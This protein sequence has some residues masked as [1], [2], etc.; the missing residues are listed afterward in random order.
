MMFGPL[1][2]RRILAF[3]LGLCTVIL[4][5]WLPALPGYSQEA[6]QPVLS[7]PVVLDGTQLFRVTAAADLSAQE[8]ASII[9]QR[10]QRLLEASDTN[11]GQFDVTV[12]E[13]SNK[14]VVEVNNQDLIT[15]TEADAEIAG[16][17]SPAT[18]ARKIKLTIERAL[19]KSYL[20]RQE[21]FLIRSLPIAV[22]VLI[23]AGLGHWLVGLL[24]AN[25]VRPAL[26]NITAF[27]VQNGESELTGVNLLL[28]VSLFLVR[29]SMWLTAI[30][31]VTNLFPVTRRL[32]YLV[33]EGLVDG[34]LARSLTLGENS[35]S[36]LDLVILLGLLLGLVILA[37]T[38]TNLLKS[39]IL[40]ITGINRGSQEAIAVLAKYS[41]IFIGAVVIL[42]I[43]GLDL[44]SLA[45]LASALGVGIGLGLQ[46]I[47][48]DFVSGLIMVFERPVQVG[49]FVDFGEFLGTVE[50]IGARS[51]EIRTIDHVSIIV[52]NSRFLEEEVINWSHRNPVSRLRLPVGVSY[53]SHPPNVREAL[54][55]ACAEN[56][57]ILHSPSP[58]VFFKG[59]GD[60]ALE[61]ELLVWISQPSKQYNIKSELYFAIEASLKRYGIEVP[62]PQRDLHIRSGSLPIQIPQDAQRWLNQLIDPNSQ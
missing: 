49:D 17:D 34:L 16:A 7:E 14:M 5:N 24:W 36:V 39:R 35:Y 40:R 22:G 48:K 29:A 2:L 13:Q 50:R 51:T 62:F 30:F 54:L 15:V 11:R 4:V 3:C 57:Q 18:Q 55:H 19:Q 9:Q 44:S 61:F 47:A 58:Q 59:F 32:T 23:A 45:L 42:Q 41:L 10:L 20:E 27:G 1:P 33:T 8:R 43:W 31:Y 6:N 28:R 38:F 60:S 37:S 53:S 25:Q 52:P 21:G 56:K 46:N 26:E 12:T